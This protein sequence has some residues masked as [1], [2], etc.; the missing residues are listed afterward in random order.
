MKL[1]TW[2]LDGE[3]LVLAYKED[4]NSVLGLKWDI[5]TNYNNNHWYW[6][7]LTDKEFKASG[8]KIATP[9]QVKS[10]FDKTSISRPQRFKM[11]R[12]MW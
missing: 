7:D 8:Y 9:K 3:F 12:S 10:I 4:K 6:Q 1:L 5:I 2:Y 11:I